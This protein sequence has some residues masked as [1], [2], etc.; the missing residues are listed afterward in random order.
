VISA[1]D[2]PEVVSGLTWTDN[3]EA[4]PGSVQRMLAHYLGGE[5]AA[6]G[7]YFGGH[8][9]VAG[10]FELRAEGRYVQIHDPQ[11]FVVARIPESGDIRLERDVLMIDEP[12]AG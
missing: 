4:A 7:Y 3:G 1:R 9:P 10:G 11:R 5:E 12:P 6:G 2:D 8:R